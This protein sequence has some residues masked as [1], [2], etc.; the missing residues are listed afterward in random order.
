VTAQNGGHAALGWHGRKPLCPLLIHET[1]EFACDNIFL[2]Y[3]ADVVDEERGVGL[4]ESLGTKLENLSPL[5][6]CGVAGIHFST[7]CTSL[8]VLLLGLFAL[9]LAA[10]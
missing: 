9:T 2:V 4:G 6:V 7:N 3:T 5:L 10:G 8:E 1:K